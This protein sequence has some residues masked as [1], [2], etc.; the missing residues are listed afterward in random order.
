MYLLA[1]GLVVRSVAGKKGAATGVVS[2]CASI[3]TSAALS[4]L[5]NRVIFAPL[6]G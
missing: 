6:L 4:L 5:F 1:S 2:G 3:K